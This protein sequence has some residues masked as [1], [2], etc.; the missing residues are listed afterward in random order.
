MTRERGTMNSP[1]AVV[2]ED[3]VD[4]GLKAAWPNHEQMIGSET[5]R[6][7]MRR[8]LEAVVPLAETRTTRSLLAARAKTEGR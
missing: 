6:E 3:W 8:G 4:V 1:D 2:P 5:A 7:Q